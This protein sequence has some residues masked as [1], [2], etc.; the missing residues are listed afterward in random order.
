MYALEFLSHLNGEMGEIMLY[1]GDT[2][3]VIIINGESPERPVDGCWRVPPD[4]EDARGPYLAGNNYPK[5]VEIAPAETYSVLHDAYYLGPDSHCFPADTYK[6]TNEIEIGEEERTPVEL[7]Y[8][9]EVG[10]EG[11]FEAAVEYGE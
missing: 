7:T 10:S 4:E 6:T 11:Q 8:S 3:R 2:G 9:V 1:P 5:E